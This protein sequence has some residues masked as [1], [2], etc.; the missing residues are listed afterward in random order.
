MPDMIRKQFYIEPRQEELLKR[1]A[2]EKGVTEAELV[3]EALDLYTPWGADVSPA[4]AAGGLRDP[5]AWQEERLFI[6]ELRKKGPV[7]GKRR[8]QREDLYE[9]R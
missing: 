4:R 3:R 8:W 6:E 5:S 2:R 9:E 1:W 7:K